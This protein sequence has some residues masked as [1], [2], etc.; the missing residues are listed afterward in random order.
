MLVSQRSRHYSSAAGMAGAA[1][2]MTSA[3]SRPQVVVCMV[4]TVPVNCP[5]IIGLN[6]A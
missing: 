6:G 1:A 2:L 3:Q 4:T 5:G